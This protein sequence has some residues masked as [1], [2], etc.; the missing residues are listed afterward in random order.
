MQPGRRIRPAD[1]MRRRRLLQS[2]P[3]RP[4]IREIRIADVLILADIP[5]PMLRRGIETQYPPRRRDETP[6]ST[7]PYVL[8]RSI[9]SGP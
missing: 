3:C 5:S 6:P 4:S 7:E 2:L 1:V 8:S 9:L